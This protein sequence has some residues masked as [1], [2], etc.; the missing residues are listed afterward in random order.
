MNKLL[1]KIRNIDGPSLT[2]YLALVAVGMLGIISL[3]VPWKQ[4][5][6]LILLIILG[7]SIGYVPKSNRGRHLLVGM[8]TMIVSLLLILH[9]ESYIF[10][11]LFFILSP[12]ATML[13][14][15]RTA[16]F[17]I[18]FFSVITILFSIRSY[19][20]SDGLLISLA[21]MS[22]FVFFGVFAS[23]LRSAQVARQESQ[24]LLEELQIANQRLKEYASRI[25]SLA[26]AEERNRVARE[27]HDTIGHRLTVAAVQLEGA[28]RLIPT[29]P[30]RAGAMIG[31]V[32]EQ[33]KEALAELRQT[34]ATLRKPLDAEFI[35][36]WALIN[37]AKFFQEATG[38]PVETDIQSNIPDLPE[39]QRIVLYRAT[40]EAL[41][42]IQRHAQASRVKLALSWQE[43]TVHLVIED[44][45][46]GFAEL[47]SAGAGEINSTGYGL[48]G[49]RERAER[50]G[51]DVILGNKPDGG[52]FLEIKI[53]Q[54]VK[55]V[56]HG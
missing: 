37:L 22:G 12:F 41:T 13:F 39:E 26:V 33:V 10:L 20:L 3:D 29:N 51:G 49:L 50:V 42:N 14:P 9:P 36:P 31:T 30:V 2:A 7:V 56:P 24:R 15:L 32:R 35:F 44:N 53:P 16:A 6:A 25:E 45:G 27:M 55:A 4:W 28:Q 43:S 5:V 34:V 40:Q 54:L 38:I 47:P 11:I 46:T 17:W 8:Q 19:N 23:A 18:F 48:V 52:A 21:Y 1:T